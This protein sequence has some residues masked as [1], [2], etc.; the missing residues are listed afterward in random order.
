MTFRITFHYET[1]RHS[2]R[3]IRSTSGKIDQ[4]NFIPC[5]QSSITIRFDMRGKFDILEFYNKYFQLH[6][7]YE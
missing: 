6:L 3:S 5:D 1:Q 2:K 4:V 7:L